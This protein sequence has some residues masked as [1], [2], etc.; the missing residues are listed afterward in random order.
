[1]TEQEYKDLLTLIARKRS[2]SCDIPAGRMP[3]LNIAAWVVYH[4]DSVEKL[5]EVISVLNTITGMYDQIQKD[6]EK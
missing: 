5:L 2:F 4:C 3:D 6:L 1:M